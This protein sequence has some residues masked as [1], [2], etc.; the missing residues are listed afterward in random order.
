MEQASSTHPYQVSGAI[1]VS[2]NIKTLSY[3]SLGASCVVKD[4]QYDHGGLYQLS[5]ILSRMRQ[6]CM[7]MILSLLTGCP[8]VG[9]WKSSS[10][11]V[12]ACGPSC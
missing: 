12:V 11:S 8:R 6:N 10:S 9:W 3:I 7:A 2:P 4:G 5:R 1:G